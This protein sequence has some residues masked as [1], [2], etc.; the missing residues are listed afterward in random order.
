MAEIAK[1]SWSAATRSGSRKPR[2]DDSWVV[3][4]SNAKGSRPL[5]ERGSKSLAMHDL[6]FAISD[7]MGGGNAGDLASAMI[8]ERMAEIIP[9]TFKAAAAGFYPDSIS[10]LQQAVKD[11]HE[12]INKAAAASENQNGMAATLALAWFSPENMYLANVGDSR[13]Y[14]CREGVTEQ[15]SKDHTLVW[16]QFKRG[17]IREAQYRMH[18]RR[19]ALYQVI[20]GSHPHVCPF[21][22]AVAFQP[23]DRF[24]ICSDGLIDGLWDRQIGNAL[25]EKNKPSECCEKLLLRA[26]DNSGLDDTTLIV[27]EIE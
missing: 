7:G 2:N 24:L 20:G 25:A 23:G 21:F 10:Y 8:L 13:I 15:V 27:I 6:V 11:V 4:S 18:P 16:G 19:S 5:R 1:I 3:F 14:H 12:H 22:A 26:L 9:E 17:E